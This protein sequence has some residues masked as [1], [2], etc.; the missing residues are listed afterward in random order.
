MVVQY[1]LLLRVK[2]PVACRSPENRW[3]L[4]LHLVRQHSPLVDKVPRSVAQ[5]FKNNYYKQEFYQ[6]F[7]FYCYLDILS[8]I[9]RQ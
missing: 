4:L 2:V 7:N 3:R 9:F 1:V 6:I 5:Q 8:R